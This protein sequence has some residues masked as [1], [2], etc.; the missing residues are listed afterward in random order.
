[1]TV[2]RLVLDSLPGVGQPTEP[3]YGSNKLYEQTPTVYAHPH[4]NLVCSQLVA[5][6]LGGNRAN[7]LVDQPPSRASVDGDLVLLGST[8]MRNP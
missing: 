6:L 2:L 5:R 8:N 1:M 4:A 3:A 7:P